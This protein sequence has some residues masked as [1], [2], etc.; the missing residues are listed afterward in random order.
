MITADLRS[1][2]ARIVVEILPAKFSKLNLL[3][4]MV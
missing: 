1:T 4:M 2:L 3:E